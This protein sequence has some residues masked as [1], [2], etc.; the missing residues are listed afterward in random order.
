MFQ[1]FKVGIALLLIMSF[2]SV[3]MAQQYF[4]VEL[5]QTQFQDDHCSDPFYSGE[6]SSSSR[7]YFD[8]E[9]DNLFSKKKLYGEMLGGLDFRRN[10]F[11]TAI[12]GD[13]FIGGGFHSLNRISIGLGIMAGLSHVISADG[14]YDIP[15]V[16]NNTS[17]DVKYL[18]LMLRP[19]LSLDFQLFKSVRLGTGL[20][21]VM[22]LSPRYSIVYP[23][24]GFDYDFSLFQRSF[25]IPVR[26]NFV[27]N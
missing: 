14:Y 3:L 1:L 20:N 7:V 15:Y 19:N 9:R 23:R 11:G 17:P 22:D 5:S 4:G 8:Y 21:Y 12:Y 25:F 6:H 2:S 27:L 18:V 24:K 13:H 26:L 16:S 10:R